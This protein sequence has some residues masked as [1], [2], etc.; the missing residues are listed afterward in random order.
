[1]L[2]MSS[3]PFQKK[4]ADVHGVPHRFPLQPGANVPVHGELHSAF[5]RVVLVDAERRGSEQNLVATRSQVLHSGP[6]QVPG[7]LAGQLN[8]D[9]PVPVRI[10]LA[11]RGRPIA[12]HGTV[13]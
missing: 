8:E 3:N 2:R 10:L 9:A 7:S 4:V 12:P 13:P 11:Q 5:D 6:S 1:M